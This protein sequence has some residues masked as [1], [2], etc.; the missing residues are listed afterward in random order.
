M[1]P[2]FCWG[3]DVKKAFISEIAQ[4][5]GEGA[6]LDNS[7]IEPIEHRQTGF[8]CGFSNDR[9]IEIDGFRLSQY[10]GIRLTYC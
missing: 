4:G 9:K 3:N 5:I 1:Q 10:S 7:N 8:V 2:C 6:E